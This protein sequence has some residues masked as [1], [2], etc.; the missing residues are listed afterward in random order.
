MEGT[1]RAAKE[2]P[3]GWHVLSR[4]CCSGVFERHEGTERTTV[5]PVLPLELWHLILQWARPTACE[6]YLLARV[7]HAW[8]RMMI[9]RPNSA[10][11]PVHLGALACRMRLAH[12]AIASDN[13]TL[14]RWAIIGAQREPLADE[15]VVGALWESVAKTSAIGCAK[16]MQ[17]VFRWPP[18][19]DR[20]KE[21]H[22]RSQSACGNCL[23]A[24]IIVNAAGAPTTEVLAM[25][26]GDRAS[27]VR[28]WMCRVF[29]GAIKD[30]RVDVLECIDRCGAL[31]T[32]ARY[33]SADSMVCFIGCAAI[34]DR[35]DLLE[36]LSRHLPVDDCV[37]DGAL[38]EAAQYNSARAAEW[39][40]KRRHVG[41]FVEAMWH[42]TAPGRES[43][44]QRMTPYIEYARAY[45]LLRGH[46][47]AE[48]VADKCAT[49]LREDATAATRAHVFRAL[50]A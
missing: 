18:A 28:C 37:M 45:H 7:C 19:C 24:R 31:R 22:E 49:E 21:Y 8:W 47:L 26:I 48:M 11:K 42:A 17:R 43:A 13:V 14:L 50:F 4:I 12:T 44:L 9:P 16:V 23:C 33:V 20:N 34:G 15:N 36:W 40:C 29:P 46:D 2:R 32:M 41:R 25:L 27:P 1:M 5:V 39:L 10:A 6:R 38:V 30:G 35:V 3:W